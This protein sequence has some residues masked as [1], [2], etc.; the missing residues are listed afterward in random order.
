MGPGGF[1]MGDISSYLSTTI[2]KILCK[3]YKPQE[4]VQ[5]CKKLVISL[6]LKNKI[7]SL[8]GIKDFD[9][10]LYVFIVIIINSEACD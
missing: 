7:K 9:M 6:S 8:R 1:Y 2:G 4:V 10:V 5:M 3:H